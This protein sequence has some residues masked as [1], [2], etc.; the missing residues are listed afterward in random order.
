MS[1]LA[2]K[3]THIIGFV[4]WFAGLFYIVRLFIYH[5]EA[6]ARPDEERRILVPQFL[7]MQRRLW[8]G[9][10]WPAMIVTVS[11]GLWLAA[12][13]GQWQLPW[14]HLKLASVG[15]LAVYHLIC[16]R[17]F[18]QLRAG[19]SRWS[20]HA[21]RIWNEVATLLLIAIVCVAVLKDGILHAW[22]PMLLV[23]ISI[24]L[25]VAISIYARLRH[26]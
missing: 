9:I 24:I 22:A 23:L 3:A 18:R 12:L 15:V 19:N 14:V 20:S 21:L 5:T 13:Y 10:T 1:Y 7:L 6:L 17:I 26:K 25:L 11:G 16:G 2:I 8:Y 4:A